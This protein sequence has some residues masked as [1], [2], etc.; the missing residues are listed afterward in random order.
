MQMPTHVFLD[1]DGAVVELIGS[2][3]AAL[4]PVQ[5]DQI[6]QGR[7]HRGHVDLGRLVPAAR[8]HVVLLDGP[9]PLQRRRPLFRL[10]LFT[11]GREHLP[12]E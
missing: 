1:L 5:R 7:R 4:L 6:L 11:R 2:L 8:D 3:G 10:V 12:H 9:E